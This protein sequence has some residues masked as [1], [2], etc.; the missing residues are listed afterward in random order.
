M[1]Y[2]AA[3]RNLDFFTIEEISRNPGYSGHGVVIRPQINQFGRIRIGAEIFGSANAP[4]HSRSSF[5]CAKFVQS[6][7][8]IDSFLG[9]IQYFFEHEVNL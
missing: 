3:Y 5:I 6:D 1:Y 2:K 9:Q 4:R 8:S 7:D